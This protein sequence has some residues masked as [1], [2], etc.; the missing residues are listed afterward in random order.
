M[1]IKFNGQ[2]ATHCPQCKQGVSGFFAT[3][4]FVRTKIPDVFDSQMIDELFS[5]SIND[6]SGLTEFWRIYALLRWMAVF[7]VSLV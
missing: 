2:A 1:G 5:K 3:S 7:E 6:N 4:S